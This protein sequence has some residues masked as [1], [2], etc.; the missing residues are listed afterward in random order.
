MNTLKT[1][2]RCLWH[3]LLDLY[4]FGVG[5]IALYPTATFWLIVGLVVLAVL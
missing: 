3:R 1:L 4:G 5:A 2:G